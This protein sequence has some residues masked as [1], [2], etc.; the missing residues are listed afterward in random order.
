RVAVLPIFIR[1]VQHQDGLAAAIRRAGDAKVQGQGRPV[2]FR[3]SLQVNKRVVTRPIQGAG[4][5][6][7]HAQV[8][9]FNLFVKGAWALHARSFSTAYSWRSCWKSVLGC[10]PR[11]S[12]AAWLLKMEARGLF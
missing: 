3:V 7:R 12:L 9:V 1:L 6:S 5:N 4:F 2:L 10:Q 8:S 11:I